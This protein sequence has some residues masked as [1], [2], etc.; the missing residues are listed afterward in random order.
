MMYIQV[1]IYIC[2]DKFLSLTLTP[3]CCRELAEGVCGGNEINTSLVL[4]VTFGDS[5]D[6]CVRAS[7]IPTDSD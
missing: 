7:V 5:P 1:P 4:E 3:S 6:S 2:V